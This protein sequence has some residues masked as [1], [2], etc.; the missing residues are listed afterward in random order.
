MSAFRFCLDGKQIENGAFL[1]NKSKY[2]LRW[3]Q[4][5]SYQSTRKDLKQPLFVDHQV[6]LAWRL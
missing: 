1:V 2:P 3:R 6:E 5:L 4:T